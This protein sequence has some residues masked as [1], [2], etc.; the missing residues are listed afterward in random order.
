MNEGA[1]IASW[2]WQCFTSISKAPGALITG[3]TVVKRSEKKRKKSDVTE[4]INIKQLWSW[5]KIT[6]DDNCEVSKPF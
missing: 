3:N 2:E 4:W 6:A 1:L 5:K